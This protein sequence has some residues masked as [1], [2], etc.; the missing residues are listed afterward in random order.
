MEYTPFKE[1]WLFWTLNSWKT[2]SLQVSPCSFASRP[3]TIWPSVNLPTSDV[4]KSLNSYV[5]VHF[6]HEFNFNPIVP[7]QGCLERKAPGKEKP[8]FPQ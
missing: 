1:V 3:E 6:I 5:C 7:Y 2:T 4:L 8:H